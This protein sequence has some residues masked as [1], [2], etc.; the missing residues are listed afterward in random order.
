M[1]QFSYK[2][3]VFFNITN[4]FVVCC[5]S[6]LCINHSILHSLIFVRDK[7]RDIKQTVLVLQ[8]SQEIFCEEIFCVIYYLLYLVYNVVLNMT[9]FKKRQTSIFLECINYS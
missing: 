3:N 2:K 6:R 7:A 9:I 8:K 5:Y 4:N 1:L